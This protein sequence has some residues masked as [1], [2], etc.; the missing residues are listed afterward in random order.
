MPPAQSLEGAAASR[1]L[2]DRTTKPGQTLDRRIAKRLQ[3]A[4]AAL[5]QG[6]LERAEQYLALLA[7][8]CPE[9]PEFL[10][11]QAIACDR[12]GRSGEAVAAMQRALA[13]Y[14][15][16][17]VFLN[18]MATVYYHAGEFDRAVFSLRRACDVQG[19]LAIAWYNL[20]IV[21]TRCV[22][23]D[24]AIDAFRRAINLDP[25]HPSIRAQLAE[26]LR[27]AGQIAAA[28]AE[29]RKILKDRM[30]SGVAWQGL[31]DLKT[32]AW[33]ATDLDGMRKALV[34]PQ[35]AI[36]DKVAIGYALARALEDAGL[37]ADS[38]AALQQA[39]ALQ[40]H[41]SPW[42]AAAFS[43]SIDEIMDAFA[44][45]PAGANALSLGREVIF[46]VGLPRS[47]TTLVEQI[48][49]SHPD[50]QGTGELAD[51]K[52]VLMA[53]SRRRHI[54]FPGWVRAAQP[55]DWE[56]LGRE[57]LERTVQWRRSRPVFT[58]KLPSNW[59]FVGAIMAML[60]ST[61]V[62]CCRRD[63]VETCFSCY[64]QFRA[65][66]DYAG[67]F[68]DL[69][70][71]WRDYDRSVRQWR[72]AYPTRIHEHDYESMLADPQSAI[73]RLLEFCGLPWDARCVRFHENT[74]AVHTPSATQVRE[75]LRTDTARAPRYGSLL[76]PLRAALDSPAFTFETA[77]S[78]AEGSARR[79]EL[80]TAAR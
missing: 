11:L 67:T 2:R 56:R 27:D 66:L 49:S 48:L 13:S 39:K 8:T 44:P 36:D 22:R 74:R 68:A 77:S 29:Y 20:G 55:G 30:W 79:D 33:D 64:R 16:D 23:H 63:P 40:R 59:L 65:R 42:D 53:E 7:E 9:H 51:L 18:T 47:G 52:S 60:P 62:V 46:I 41:R 5:E 37:F 54:P 14:P 69:A 19:D 61:R 26:A 31:A 71:F 21:L 24:E 12:A 50:V 70:A 32:V 45:V 34:S 17:A 1:D 73:R 72:D 4:A 28:E 10:R 57:Y 15:D 43:R 80:D 75:P 3:T 78:T 76:D 38:L 25:G 6:D 35:A 58:D